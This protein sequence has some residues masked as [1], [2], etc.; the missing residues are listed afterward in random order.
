MEQNIML[1]AHELAQDKTV[2]AAQW[3]F[4]A[5]LIATLFT[6]NPLAML[7]WLASITILAV[8]HVKKKHEEKT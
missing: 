2:K 5:C 6:G 1:E 4:V 8:K 3:L 7:P